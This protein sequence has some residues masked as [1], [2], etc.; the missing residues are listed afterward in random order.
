MKN[1]FITLLILL[2]TGLSA[3]SDDNYSDE[4]LRNF[5]LVNRAL[6]EIKQ[7]QIR[8][9]DSLLASTPMDQQLW[10]EMQYDYHKLKNVDSLRISYSEQE[11]QVFYYLMSFRKGQRDKFPALLLKTE[12]KFGMSDDYFQHLSMRLQ[13][14]PTLR[15]RLAKIKIEN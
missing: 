15:D 3:Q 12:E 11:F 13:I 6:Q 1:I 10:D 7:N 2:S 5:L 8:Q 9:F 14:I 4:D